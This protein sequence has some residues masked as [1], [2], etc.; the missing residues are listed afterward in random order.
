MPE[1]SE[2]RLAEIEARANGASAGPWFVVPGSTGRDGDGEPFVIPTAV[3][4]G[5]YADE[6]EP[7]FEAVIDISE[8]PSQD[9]EFII[10]ARIDVPDLIAE[11]RRLHR[12][13]KAAEGNWADAERARRDEV[14]VNLALAEEAAL[15]NV[16]IKSLRDVVAS[17][18]ANRDMLLRRIQ[19]LETAAPKITYTGG[20]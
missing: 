19:A 4:A 14:K 20:A 1:I 11:V 13:V 15:K 2:E 10:S 18:E 7:D 3:C 8:F 6:G 16:E 12:Q 9:A 5:D 17:L